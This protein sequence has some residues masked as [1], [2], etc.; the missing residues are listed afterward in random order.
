M[1]ETV[2]DASSEFAVEMWR[3]TCSCDSKINSSYRGRRFVEKEIG[4]QKIEIERRDIDG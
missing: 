2:T 3:C 1:K 4:V